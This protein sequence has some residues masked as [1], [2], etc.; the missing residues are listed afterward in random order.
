MR[1]LNI[2]LVFLISG[3][4]MA[5]TIDPVKVFD[6]ANALYEQKNYEVAIEKYESLV[7]KNYQAE[8]VYFN[9]GNAYYQLQQVAPSIYNYK[10]ALKIN[11]DNTAA[12]T[13]LKFADKMKLDEFDKKIKLNSSQITHNTIGFFDMNEWGITAIVAIFLILISFVIFYF[14]QNPTVKKVFFTLQIVLGFVTIISIVS[15]FSEQSFQ[16]SERY[17]IVF[18][19]EVSLKVEPRTS[20]KNAQIIHEGT[21]VFIEEETT[22]WYKVILPNQISGWILKEAVREI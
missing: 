13:N 11:P 1:I 19:E 14:S 17:A 15:A 22:K 7:D 3:I 5:N 10:K 8:A 2:L 6:E 9:L 16:K 4:S 12:K 18:N 21:E 20:A